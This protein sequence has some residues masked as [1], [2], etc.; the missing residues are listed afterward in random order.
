MG[1]ALPITPLQILWVNMVT[2]VTLSLA[3]AFTQRDS[4]IMMHPPVPATARLFSNSSIF[5]FVIHMAII[6]L[7]TIGTFIYEMEE[8]SNLSL[9]HTVTI[10]MLVFFQ[11]YYLWGLFLT[12]QS[13]KAST[14]TSYL[15]LIICTFAVLLLQVFFTYNPWMQGIF[16]TQGIGVEE[17]LQIATFS[18]IIFAYLFIEATIGKSFFR[19]TVTIWDWY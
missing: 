1:F 8:S 11:I 2:A 3:F 5:S 10:N 4:S 17:W 14:L 15:P 16:Y 9:S 18:S 12:R 7:G 13:L 19:R 6:S